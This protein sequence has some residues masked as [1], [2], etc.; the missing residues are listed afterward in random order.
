MHLFFLFTDM[1]FYLILI[2]P[3][4]SIMNKLW[5]R[6]LNEWMPVLN[7]K[8]KH[9]CEH[10]SDA[11]LQGGNVEIFVCHPKKTC[12]FRL[13]MLNS[14]AS[15]SLGLTMHFFRSVLMEWDLRVLV[16]P[17]LFKSFECEIF[18]YNWPLP[19]FYGL[20][21]VNV[22]RYRILC[23]PRVFRGLWSQHIQTRWDWM[24]E[25]LS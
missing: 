11:A 19:L 24:F 1:F 16:F 22:F 13:F 6:S 20:F 4:L 2:I 21:W 15:Q 3:S 5:W 8:S 14:V 18:T 23:Y 9:I 25:V 12:Q 17:V 10:R 7:V